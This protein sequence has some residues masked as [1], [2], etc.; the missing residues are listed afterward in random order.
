[1]RR[2]ADS[3][4]AAQALLLTTAGAEDSRRPQADKSVRRH[5]LVEENFLLQKAGLKSLTLLALRS[6]L[7]HNS[8]FLYVC[9]CMF[10]F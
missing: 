2:A 8:P 5:A 7:C 1:M 4:S 9:N 3:V 10:L 6:L